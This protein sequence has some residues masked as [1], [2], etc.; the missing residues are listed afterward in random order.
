[1]ARSSQRLRLLHTARILWEDT[2]DEH[3]I[4]MEE[5]LAELKKYGIDAV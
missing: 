4:T 5:I 2:D 3:G 1:M